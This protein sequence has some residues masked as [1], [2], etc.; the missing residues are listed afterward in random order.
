[1]LRL[2]SNI[3]LLWLVKH[4]MAGERSFYGRLGFYLGHAIAYHP[5]PYRPAKFLSDRYMNISAMLIKL[6]PLFIMSIFS[7]AS[8][9]T[10]HPRQRVIKS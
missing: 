6:T 4:L 10:L 5:L 3:S 7:Y 9:S 2:A 1:M 8:S